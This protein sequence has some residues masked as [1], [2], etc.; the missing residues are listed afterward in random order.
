MAAAPLLGNTS[1]NRLF[2]YDL[3]L[4]AWGIIDLPM[5]SAPSSYISSIYQART[6]GIQPLTLIGGYDSGSIQIIQNG[7]SLWKLTSSPV[8]VKWAVTTPEIFNTGDP[9]GEVQ[10]ATLLIRGTN[11]TGNPITVTVNL[12]TEAGYITDPRV[13]NTGIGEFQLF[14][15][16]NETALSAN[17]AIS[18]SGI[19]ELESFTWN[20]QPKSSNVPMVLT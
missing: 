18:G 4:K 9:S 16:I 3:V 11:T 17:A 14:I 13:Y 5:T 1:L 20:V 2:I 12:Q 6:P 8:A 19:V 7:S 15:G 10:I